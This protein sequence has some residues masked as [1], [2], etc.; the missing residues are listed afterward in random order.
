MI[1]ET[2][3]E[4]CF[5]CE[6]LTGECVCEPPPKCPICRDEAFLG[7]EISL[8]HF[9]CNHFIAGWDDSGFH[10]S[11]LRKADAPVL[12][13]K[14]KTEWSPAKLKQV[15]GDA[16]PLLGAYG[17]VLTDEPDNEEFLDALLILLPG[18]MKQTYYDQPPG[19]MVGWE[20]IMY[21]A[22]DPAVAQK[23]FA[24]LILKLKEGF[25]YLGSFSD[26]E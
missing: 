3:E 25:K 9:S 23:R 7:G 22:E 14:L 2:E 11:P 12:S 1:D 17:G 26:G 13:E 15:F 18:V 19:S 5:Y 4:N 21:F 10:K 6:N 20:A 16:E 8:E 24:E